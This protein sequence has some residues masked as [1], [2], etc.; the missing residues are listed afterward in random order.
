LPSHNQLGT[1]RD[2]LTAHPAVLVIRRGLT[3]IRDSF[4]PTRAQQAG[5]LLVLTLFLVGLIVML[6]RGRARL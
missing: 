6:I 2:R 4:I 1:A 3:A 5:A